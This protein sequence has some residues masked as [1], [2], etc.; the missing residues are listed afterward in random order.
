MASRMLNDKDI[1]PINYRNYN[2]QQWNSTLPGR[3][4]MT[5]ERSVSGQSSRLDNDIDGLT[6]EHRECNS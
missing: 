5:I 4:E 2:E 6:P 3:G 1:V